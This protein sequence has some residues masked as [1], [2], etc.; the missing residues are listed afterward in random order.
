MI[1][2][3]LFTREVRIRLADDSSGFICTVRRGPFAAK[4]AVIPLQERPSIATRVEQ[5]PQTKAKNTWEP[6][7]L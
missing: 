5:K 1:L 2:K 6:R 7:V 4:P 3:A